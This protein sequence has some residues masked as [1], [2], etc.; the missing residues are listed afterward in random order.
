[1]PDPPLPDPFRWAGEHIAANL[2]GARVHH[3]AVRPLGPAGVHGLLRE[4]AE[5]AGLEAPDPDR[6]ARLGELC[7][8][9]PL[10]LRI[11]GG[12]LADHH[13]PERLAD[14]IEMFG[15]RPAVDRIL[16]LRYHDQP[17]PNRRLLR[18]LALTG[19]ASFGG[20]A[21]TTTTGTAITTG[22]MKGT[23]IRTAD[24]SFAPQYDRSARRGVTAAPG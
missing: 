12:A 10:A 14:D 8:G 4:L 17:E 16:A 15:P 7:A 6:A 23:T 19:R 21:R 24:P 2:P 20:R 5:A 1:M 18:R 3:C 13:G 22:T 9:L 11:A